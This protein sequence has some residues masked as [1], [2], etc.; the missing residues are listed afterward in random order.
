[1]EAFIYGMFFG[2]GSCGYY[3]CQSGN[4]YSWGINNSNNKLLKQC[5]LYLK[6]LYGETQILK[7]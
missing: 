2:D 4:K 5:T 7:F 3:E 6:E 1:M